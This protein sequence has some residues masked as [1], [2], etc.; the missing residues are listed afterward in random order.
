MKRPISLGKNK[1]ISI[2]RYNH[3]GMRATCGTRHQSKGTWKMPAAGQ[4]MP[5]L[6]FPSQVCAWQGGAAWVP[7]LSLSH[8]VV[9]F[10]FLFPYQLLTRA[11]GGRGLKISQMEILSQNRL[12]LIYETKKK[13]KTK[14][15]LKN[16][17]RFTHCTHS[18]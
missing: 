12:S 11:W 2:H 16:L 5:A 6:R 8:T 1:T 18:G 9:L 7:L 15:I 10:V 4:P 3:R 14:K 17:Q 13:T